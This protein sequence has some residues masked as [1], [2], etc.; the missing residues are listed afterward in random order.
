M[1]DD[2]LHCGVVV[3]TNLTFKNPFDVRFELLHVLGRIVWPNDQ[4]PFAW[5]GLKSVASFDQ[6]RV[7]RNDV[8]FVAEAK[9][10]LCD[11]SDRF[12]L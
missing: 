7:E 12:C 2:R 1:F 11:A 5:F 3:A 9:F 10:L 6:I 4:R 8:H